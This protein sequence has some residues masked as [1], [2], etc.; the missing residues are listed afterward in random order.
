LFGDGGSRKLR[1][2]F[3]YSFFSTQG[4]FSPNRTGG[5]DPVT[6]VEAPTE[7]KLTLVEGEPTGDFTVYVVVRDGRGG[8]TW[9]RRTATSGGG[10]EPGR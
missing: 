8:E 4:R 5:A 6:R 3:R 9:S 10:R 1:E 7:A 2:S